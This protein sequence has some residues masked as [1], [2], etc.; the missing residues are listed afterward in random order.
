MKK[1]V[2]IINSNSKITD[3]LKETLS[4]Q[5]YESIITSD[6]KAGLELVEQNDIVSILLES[7][8]SEKN[9]LELMRDLKRVNENIPVIILITMADISVG[10]EFIKQG[11]YDFIITPPKIDR[12]IF[13]LNRA[14]EQFEL[15]KK[16]ELLSSVIETSHEQLLGSSPAMKKV[17]NQITQI[18]ATGFSIIIQGETGTGKTFI[19]HAIHNLSDRNQKPFVKVDMNTISE[20][21]IES[22]LFGHEKGA[23]TGAERKKIGF[24]ELA[25]QGTIFI[26]ELQNINPQIQMK[27][28][29][30]VET[31]QFY[32]VGGSKTIDTDVRIIAATNIDIKHYVK[33]KKFREDLYY[34][35]SEFMIYLPPL[36]ERPVDILFYARKFLLEAKEELNMTQAIISDEVK[37]IVKQYPWP[38]NIRELKNSVRRAILNSKD[39]LILPRHIEFL[40]QSQQSIAIKPEEN[41]STANNDSKSEENL[42]SFQG[43][44]NLINLIRDNDELIPLKELTQQVVRQ[45]EEKAI[46]NA[47]R[48]TGNNKAKAALLLQISK[49][50]LFNKINE[51]D[52]KQA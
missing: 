21:L 7:N 13:T 48:K 17:I 40:P 36:R 26:D 11:A 49:R 52:I 46:K 3:D 6:H 8:P 37:E 24:F 32:P 5:N 31:K 50:S 35:L 28:L 25:D 15:S 19:A 16:V 14:I 23:F 27:I 43:D 44:N 51:Y 45:I 20:S 30:V 4:F 22:E 34:R 18:A 41:L 38:G 47:L 1:K 29:N 2:L 10:I 33:E 39:G 42:V 9:G 12:L